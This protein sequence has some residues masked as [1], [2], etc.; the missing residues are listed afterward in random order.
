MALAASGTTGVVSNTTQSFSGAKTFLGVLNGSSELAVTGISNLNG[1]ATIGTMATTSTLTHILGVNSSNAIGEIALGNSLTL[2]GGTL[3]VTATGTFTTTNSNYTI[4]STDKYIAFNNNF[5]NITV[6]LPSASGNTGRE[7]H[8]RNLAAGSI[9][10][11]SNNVIN[12]TVTTGT[13]DNS[14]L[15]AGN[16]NYKWCTL[17]SD[18]TYWIKMQAN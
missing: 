11:A 2:S 18:G 12:N 15:G 13:P 6:T 16:T 4:T 9:I 8:F 7:L 5:S 3:N 10:S 17:V 1:G 14:I